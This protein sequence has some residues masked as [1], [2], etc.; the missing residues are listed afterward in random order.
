M[1]VASPVE[2][3]VYDQQ[4]RHVGPNA[5][6]GIDTE[7]P[8]SAYWTPIVAGDP[9]P[10]ARRVSIP[11]GDLSHDYQIELAGTGDGIFSF[12]LE[13]PDRSTGALYHADY[14]SV[15]VAISDELTLAL[16][17]GT[18]FVLAA[19][20]DGDGIFEG[21]VAPSSVS[22]REIDVPVNL[23]LAGTAGENGWY[24]SD[25][26]AMLQESARPGLPLVDSME[27]D[28][29]SGWQTWTAPLALTQE[30]THTLHYRGTFTGGAQDVAQWVSV[31]LDKT[32]PTLTLTLPT[33]I[34]YTLCPYTGT[35][36]TGTFDVAYQA[37]DAVSGLQ[38]VGATLAGGVVTNGQTLETLFLP[39]GPHELVVAAKDRAGWRTIRR[40]PIFIK[41]QIE[42]LNCAVT[43]LWSLGLVSGPD[44]G[45]VVA[46]LQATLSASQAARD[47]GDMAAAVEHLYTFVL[48]V[49]E[50]TPAPISVDA[51]RILARGA[52]YVTN[53]MAGE[54][55]VPPV[56]GGQ[57]TSPDFDVT[58]S[59]PSTVANKAIVAAYRPVTATPPITLPLFGPVFD[60][61]A[62]EYDSE[63]PAS[64]FQRPVT[65]SVQYGDGEI[66]GLDE[67]WLALHT[68]DEIN[69]AWEMITT[70]VDLAQDRAIAQVEHF[71]IYALLEREH[72]IIFLPLVARE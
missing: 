8:G 56:F 17:R 55:I 15:T 24:K 3:H 31:R 59:F 29:G 54:I 49:A 1:L 43:R 18:G 66:G 34:T 20:R 53:R 28:L 2:I 4:G 21:Q 25:M 19:D 23:M 63:N 40:H 27:F 47:G 72:S 7:I 42:D 30:G 39:P 38:T 46:D 48:D 10:D 44:A 35:M 13:V 11:S 51:G 12:Y 37:G 58:V 6:G 5:H 69:S 45:T 9:N 33:A 67:Q 22:S 64:N 62:L 70:T 68:W 52:Q 36:Y 50:Q 32:A 57:L 26:T 65:V 41:A 16:G 71:S 60:L 14:L 61:T